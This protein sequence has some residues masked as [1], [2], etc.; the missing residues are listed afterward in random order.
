MC[1]GLALVLR[2]ILGKKNRDR[3]RLLDER[4]GQAYS[5]EEMTAYE[6]EGDDAPFFFYTL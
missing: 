2:M 5:V 1:F 4:G 3:Q 6:D